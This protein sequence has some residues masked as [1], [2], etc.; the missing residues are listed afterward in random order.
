MSDGSDFKLGGA[1][2]AGS[3]ALSGFSKI[4]ELQQKA[5]NLQKQTGAAGKTGGSESAEDV[6]KA[7]TDFEALL[8]QQMF[9][10]MWETVPKGGLITGSREEELY[11][12]MLNEQ[13]AKDIAEKQS[14]GVRDVIARD[15][16]RIQNR[17]RKP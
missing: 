12:D 4:A 6:Y 7:A 3:F 14:I 13:L 5:E 17:G 9:K 15:I 11:R 1:G 10:T 16:N 2:A 8:L